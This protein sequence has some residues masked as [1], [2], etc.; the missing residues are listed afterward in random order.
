MSQKDKDKT[1][2][3]FRKDAVATL[4]PFE[5]GEDS[6]ETKQTIT[7][8][9]EKVER[10]LRKSIDEIYNKF[11][12]KIEEKEA[13]TTEI[14]A[15]FITLFTF[16]SVNINIFTRVSDVYTGIWFMLMMTACSILILS[17][18][19]VVINS[20]NDWKVWVA[21]LVALC[22]LAFLILIT[23]SEKWNPRLNEVNQQINSK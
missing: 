14:L 12:K 17:V 5:L 20:K 15:I 8:S 2:N 21:I 18:M 11:D 1:Q 23:I 4:R 9:I 7:P 6:L 3:D 16:I 22:F 10:D 19:F 13:K